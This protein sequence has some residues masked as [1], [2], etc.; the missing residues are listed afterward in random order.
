[1]WLSSNSLLHGVDVT[2]AQL[3]W[4]KLFASSNWTWPI[5]NL[6]I[7]CL[8][9]IVMFHIRIYDNIWYIHTMYLF[10]Y[11][12]VE[13]PEGN[14]ECS[15]LPICDHQPNTSRRQKIVSTLVGSQDHH[16][17][18]SLRCIP[19]VLTV[20][21]DV[22]ASRCSSMWYFIIIIILFV[23]I[24]IYIMFPSNIF[25]ISTSRSKYVLIWNIS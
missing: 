16:P 2:S 4:L 14:W 19:T 18:S 25:D 21:I 10:I 13:F 11:I 1:M 12:H 6:W 8:L 3:M 9:S 24:Y 22:I 7:I 23:Y 5:L 20:V 17:I 15:M